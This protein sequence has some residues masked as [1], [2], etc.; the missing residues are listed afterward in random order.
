[1]ILKARFDQMVA[2]D[3]KTGSEPFVEVLCPEL[4]DAF[5]AQH[6]VVPSKTFSSSEDIIANVVTQ[7][8]PKKDADVGL[9]N[10]ETGGDNGK[11]KCRFSGNKLA[12]V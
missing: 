1:M 2:K 9:E 4:T 5:T 6:D 8:R 11:K 7:A 3:K 10:L 12:Y